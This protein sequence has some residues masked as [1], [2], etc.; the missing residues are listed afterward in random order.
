MNTT[1]GNMV[2]EIVAP[3]KR[4]VQ[5]DFRKVGSLSVEWIRGLDICYPLCSKWC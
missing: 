5:N 2:R 4:D 1:V 3:I